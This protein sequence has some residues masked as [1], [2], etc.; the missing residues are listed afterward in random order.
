MFFIPTISLGAGAN[1][2]FTSK[3]ATPRTLV[4]IGID[5]ISSQYEKEFTLSM[6]VA[7]ILGVTDT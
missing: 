6:S 3:H 1:T 4:W 7:L 2:C 5:I